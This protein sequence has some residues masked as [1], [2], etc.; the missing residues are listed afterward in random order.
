MR[1]PLKHP[2]LLPS[3]HNHHQSP[4]TPQTQESGTVSH[5]LSPGSIITAG[6]LL[7]QIQLK[8]P[9]KVR[10][11]Y[12]YIYMSLWRVCVDSSVG[13]INDCRLECVCRHPMMLTRRP[14]PLNESRKPQVKKITP[15]KGTLDLGAA[16]ADDAAASVDGVRTALCLYVYMCVYS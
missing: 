3:H 5:R 10:D 13:Y 11:P 9:S 14:P 1:V 4:Q 15:F 8:D 2:Q 12:I 16:A 6:D 7:A